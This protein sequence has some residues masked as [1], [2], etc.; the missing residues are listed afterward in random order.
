[1]PASFVTQTKTKIWKIPALGLCV[2]LLAAL[3]TACGGTTDTNYDL[4]VPNSVTPVDAVA[5]DND[6]KSKVL[7]P[8]RAN[9]ILDQQV[10]VYKTGLAL[11]DL[12]S[13]YTTE[14]VKRGWANVSASILKN[15]ELGQQGLVMAFEKPL[16]DP[17]KKRVV[18]IILLSPEVKNPLLDPYRTNGTLPK[19]QNVVI[20]IEGG[21]GA[22]PSP[23]PAG[24]PA[25][26]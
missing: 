26:K 8:G 2:V 25:P 20:A 11:A 15:D 24:T 5:N 18:G 14:M 13:S 4:F 16:P 19:D 10:T 7:L 6:F 12:Q 9:E 3:L 23:A 17:S 22:V 1:M 21:T